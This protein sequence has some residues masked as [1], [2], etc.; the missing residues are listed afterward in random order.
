MQPG[1]PEPTPAPTLADA[2]PPTLPS[3]SQ[4]FARTVGTTGSVGSARDAIERGETGRL[5]IYALSMLLW[6]VAGIAIV[7]L[8]PGSWT[9]KELLW[10]SLVFMIVSYG[11]MWRKASAVEDLDMGEIFPMGIIQA[12]CAVAINYGMGIF[13]PLPALIAIGLT[14]YCLSAPEIHALAIYLVV[15]LGYGIV[16]ALVLAGVLPDV[17]LLA[18]IDSTFTVRLS[19]YIGIELATLTAYGVGRLAKR[20]NVRVVEALEKA[21]RDASRREVLLREAREE[22]ERAAGLGGAGRFT[23]QELGSYRLGA[24]IG[25][26]GMGEVYEASHLATGEEAAVKLMRRDVLGDRALVQRFE[27]E[28]QIVAEIHSAHV[29]KVLEVGGLEAPLPYIAMERLRGVDLASRLRDEGRL[30]VHDLV[31]L[32]RE[33]G[34]GLAAAH[35]RDV[36]HRDLKPHNLFQASYPNGTTRWKVLDFGVSKLVGSAESTLTVGQ[37]VGTPSYMAPEQA[38]PGTPIDHRADLYSLSVILYR[39]LTGA[40]P[41]TRGDVAQVV[42][43]V[44]ED[45]PQDPSELRTIEIDLALVLRIGL[46]KEPDDRFES[47]EELAAA[48]ALAAKGKLGSAYRDKA[49]AL[50][51]GHPWGGSPSRRSTVPPA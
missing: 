6:C 9:A 18:A 40:A 8:I 50:L 26:G 3:A 44:L 34:D 16:G 20:D 25:R 13:S 49:R 51:Q 23:D 35:A 22:L 1:A 15:A 24:V 4:G 12:L 19:C 14:L 33:V 31:T 10:G 32:A 41:F 37:L 46:A 17:G 11:W 38:R 45:M 30:S 29:V 36:V 39:A 47:A 27:R 5:R 21:V 7:W 43:A 42:R 28:A 2:A 48:F